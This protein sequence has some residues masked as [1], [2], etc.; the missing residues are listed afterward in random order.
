MGYYKRGGNG[1]GRTVEFDDGGG[2]MGDRDGR[3]EAVAEEEGVAT[4]AG[5]N[6]CDRESRLRERLWILCEGVGDN[7]RG[8]AENLLSE[9][10][11]EMKFYAGKVNI[12]C[13]N[14]TPW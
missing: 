9:W 13:W 3:S 1:E 10:V 7:E 14:L 8:R 6:G 12:F 11:E 4:V 5:L 2:G